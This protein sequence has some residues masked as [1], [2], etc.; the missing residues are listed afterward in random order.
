MRTRILLAVCGV[1]L[2]AFEAF[3]L[4]TQ[5]GFSDL[6]VLAL[7]LAAA[8][9]IH[10]GILSPL[11]VSAGWAI[12]RFVPSRGRPYLQFGLVVAVLV[13][14]IAVPLIIREDTQPGSKAILNQAYGG[15]LTIL[16]AHNYEPPTWPRA[17]CSST[18]VRADRSGSDPT[19]VPA[20]LD[21]PARPRCS[22]GE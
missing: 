1:A 2:A 12:S 13:T 3:R 7:W 21:H 11:V 19:R 14:V 15:N 8:V 17:G 20:H 22:R 16:L 4:L 10:D 9:A 18:I 6:V 5:V